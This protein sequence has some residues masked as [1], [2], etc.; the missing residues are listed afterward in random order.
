MAT[1]FKDAIVERAQADR[2]A[3]RPRD[4]RLDP[5]LRRIEP[6]LAMRAQRLA[7]SVEVERLFERGLAA[8]ELAHDF[9]ERLERILEAESGDVRP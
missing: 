6:G 4:D 1:S 8:L 9:L 5:R 7:A 3:V 2:L